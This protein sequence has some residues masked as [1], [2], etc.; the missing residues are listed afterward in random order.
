[1]WS[2]VRFMGNLSSKTLKCH[3]SA[4]TY[5]LKFLL[6]WERA[7][8]RWL[9]MRVLQKQLQVFTK[10]IQK[11]SFLIFLTIYVPMLYLATFS[12]SNAWDFHPVMTG[13]SGNVPAT[14]EDLRR[15]SGDFRAFEH[16]RS[17]LR[18][19]VCK[20]RPEL[21]KINFWKIPKKLCRLP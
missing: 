19:D 5:D 6:L 14:S 12:E 16:F 20:Y 13:S 15:L 9:L 3:I 7:S 4:M 2:N 17:Y 1:M 21:G 18:A 11:R 10:M 8:I